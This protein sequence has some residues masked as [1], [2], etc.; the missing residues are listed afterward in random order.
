[1]LHLRWTPGCKKNYTTTL[2]EPTH[3]KQH[4]LLD[5][6]CSRPLCEC[7]LEFAYSNLDDLIFVFVLVFDGHWQP[8]HVKIDFCVLKLEQSHKT[9]QI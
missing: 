4:N 7:G 9:V 6:F 1:M 3:N 5:S 2:Q 8:F